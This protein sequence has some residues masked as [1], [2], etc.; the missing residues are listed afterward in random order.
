MPEVTKQSLKR[1]FSQ[2]VKLSVPDAMAYFKTDYRKVRNLFSELEKDKLI[3]LV[4]DLEYEFIPVVEKNET[5]K[6]SKNRLSKAF[7]DF[8]V[9]EDDDDDDD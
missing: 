2:K 3:R 9:D 4:N 5:K 6:N 7:E 1:F 8:F